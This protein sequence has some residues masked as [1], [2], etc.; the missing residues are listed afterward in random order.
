MASVLSKAAV[1][2]PSGKNWVVMVL[3][4]IPKM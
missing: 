4:S 1:A 2:F 3:A